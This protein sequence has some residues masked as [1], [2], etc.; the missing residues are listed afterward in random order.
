MFT[1]PPLQPT[2]P[3]HESV[4]VVPVLNSLPLNR[5]PLMVR[6]LPWAATNPPWVPSPMTLLLMVTLL[7]QLV[8]L[9]MPF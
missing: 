9:A 1:V 3:P 5:Q 7:T 4:A 2:K 6:V 8:M